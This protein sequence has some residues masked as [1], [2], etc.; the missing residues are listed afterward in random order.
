MDIVKRLRKWMPEE[1]TY[2]LLS[3][4]ADEIERLRESLKIFAQNV[5]ETNV[6][7]DKNWAKTVNA[8]KAENQRLREEILAIWEIL[9]V[10]PCVL[11]V[12][13]TGNMPTD[14]DYVDAM[15]K[16]NKGVQE[17]IL[18][19]NASWLRDKALGEKE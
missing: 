5:K 10:F 11:E 15:R 9:E 14:K 13:N 4:A 6:G 19:K 1:N 8:L 2:E 7:I 18:E 3:D 17:R 16:W 12:T